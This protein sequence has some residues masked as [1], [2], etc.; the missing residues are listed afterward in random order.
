M[1]DLNARQLNTPK[2][3]TS[4]GFGGQRLLLTKLLSE[5]F[6]PICWESP[7]I[8]GEA[9]AANGSGPELSA[10]RQILADDGTSFV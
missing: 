5:L 6:L 10:F 9:I 7:I 1:P 4:K 2:A 8:L 3:F